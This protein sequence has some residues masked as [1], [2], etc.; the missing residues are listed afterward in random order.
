[1]RAVEFNTQ[2]RDHDLVLTEEIKS[3]LPESGQARVI[4]LFDGDSE[5][6]TWRQASYKKFLQDDSQEDHVYDQLG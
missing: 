1:M 6:A 5:D 4:V 3:H 2:L